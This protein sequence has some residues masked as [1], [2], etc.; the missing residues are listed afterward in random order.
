MYGGDPSS[1]PSVREEVEAAL[2]VLAWTQRQ[3]NPVL[4]ERM[5]MPAV[6]ADPTRS[7][8]FGHS[9][10]G[11]IAWRM[12][13][14]GPRP[15]VAGAVAGVD[16][17]DG[18]APPFPPGG[19][20]ELVIDDDP[21][22]FGFPF[23]SLILGAGRGADGVPGFECA[24]ANRN[25]RL[26]YDA[27]AAPRYEMVANDFGHSDMLNGDS[28]DLVCAGNLSG[29]R[30][31]MRAWVSGQLAAYFATVLAGRDLRSVLRD[32]TLAPVAASGRFED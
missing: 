15:Y 30:A 25:Y 24:P 3:I 2:D 23:P 9:R 28:P 11:Q 10:G 14:D 7:G 6:R 22:G 27:S 13:F 31:R 19:T 17:V 21:A 32:P 1:A 20:G 4:S 26:F 5:A 29:Q 16:P 8:L 18:D 12:L